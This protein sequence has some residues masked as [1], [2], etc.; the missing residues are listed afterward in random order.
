MLSTSREKVAEIVSPWAVM[1]R[2]A[3][4]VESR[5]PATTYIAPRL[6]AP[7]TAD[8]CISLVLIIV[9][10]MPMSSGRLASCESSLPIA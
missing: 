2:R 9:Q 5:V 8:A 6:R 1:L 10:T 7:M 4:G 3:A